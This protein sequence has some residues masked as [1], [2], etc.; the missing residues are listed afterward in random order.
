MLAL[1][2]FAY[3]APL[4]V[5]GLAH[6]FRYAY[7]GIAASCMVLVLIATRPRCASA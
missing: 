3:I 4:A 1:S 2:A 6:D 7:W 5:V